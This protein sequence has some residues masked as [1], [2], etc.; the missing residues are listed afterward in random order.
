[1]LN[2]FAKENCKSSL[3]PKNKNH[4]SENNAM[5]NNL[6]IVIKLMK[7]QNLSNEI[8]NLMREFKINKES[9]ES[10][11]KLQFDNL[12]SRLAINRL[13]I[14][15]SFLQNSNLINIKR[16]IVESLMIELFSRY[17]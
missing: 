3:K 2:N 11:Y 7:I 13:S 17:Q 14:M 15:I 4:N 8:S 1:M 16:K 10:F 9:L 6:S 12:T 5:F